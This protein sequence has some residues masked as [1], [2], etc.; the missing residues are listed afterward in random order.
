[1]TNPNQTPQ[2][3]QQDDHNREGQGRQQ[4]QQQGGQERQ[5]GGQGQ[6]NRQPEQQR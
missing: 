2:P 4:E 1:M 6:P 5:P 3:G